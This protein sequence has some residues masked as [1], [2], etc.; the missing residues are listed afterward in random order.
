[1][2]TLFT[3][4]LLLSTALV[5]GQK[6]NFEFPKLTGTTLSGESVSIPASTN[7]KVTLLGVAYSKKAEEDLETWLDPVYN[8]FIAKT[9][10]M[11]GL[12]DVHM[13]FVPM[14]SGATKSAQQTIM[15]NM[16]KSTPKDAQPHVLFF[17]ESAEDYIEPCGMQDKKVPY[18]FVLS[19]TGQVIYSTSGAFTQQKL[20]VIE[21]LIIDF[22]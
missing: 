14:F 13:F 19:P 7:G 8:K 1:M 17:N 4:L 16:K 9:G 6:N 22:M 2:K 18:F 3:A 15:N 11:D 5:F 21:E 12:F 20:D 10:M